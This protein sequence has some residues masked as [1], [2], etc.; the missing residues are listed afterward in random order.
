VEIV[1]TDRVQPFS[2][3]GKNAFAVATTVDGS[4]PGSPVAAYIAAGKVE[5]E[6]RVVAFGH[7]DYIDSELVLNDTRRLNAERWAAK[8]NPQPK[9]SPTCSTLTA[10]GHSGT[11]HYKLSDTV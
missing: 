11:I 2:V 10:V 3:F 1:S 5:G 6:G 9:V 7:K 8:G 4:V